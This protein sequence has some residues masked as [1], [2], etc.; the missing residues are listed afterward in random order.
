MKLFIFN[1]NYIV[2]AE[3]KVEALKKVTP[4]LQSGHKWYTKP[5]AEN[6]LDQ[7][8]LTIDEFDFDNDVLC[9]LPTSRS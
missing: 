7:G 6:P 3:T 9:C 8:H 1:C 2:R 4:F 5:N